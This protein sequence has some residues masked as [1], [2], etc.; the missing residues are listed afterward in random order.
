MDILS[1]FYETCLGKVN[2]AKRQ[3]SDLTE[4][5]QQLILLA[6]QGHN[7][8]VDACI[9]SG[10]TS[11]IQVLCDEFRDKKILYLTYNTL[12]KLDAQ[13]KISNPNAKVT[14]YHGYV[15][16]VLLSH[17]ITTGVSDMLQRFNR[18]KPPLP[19]SF[20]M[21]VLDE[22]QDIEQEIA[23]M[24][25]YVK[26]QNPGVQIIAVGDMAQKIYDKTTLNVPAFID[27]FLGT[28]DKLCFTK[29]FRLNHDHAAMLGRIWN[30][31]INGVNENCK[32]RVMDQ[33]E[34]VAYLA[35]Q[36]PEDVLCLGSRT[37]TLTEVL[38]QLEEEVPN[39][40]N[41]NTTYASIRD[42]DGN[43]RPSEKNAIFTTY[44]SAKGLERKICVV[45]DFTESYWQVRSSIAMTKY[46]IL[47]NIFCVAASR[48]KDEII[49]VKDR[50]G[51][52][53][54]SEETL[55]CPFIVNDE[56]D[57][58]FPISSMFDF[59]Y[60]E[61]VEEAYSYLT[62]KE[63]SRKDHAEIYV[64]SL[65]GLIDLSPCIGIYQEA[66]F[67]RNYDIDA[68]I[69]FQKVMSE[70]RSFPKLPDGASLDEKILYLTMMETTQNRYFEQVSPPFVDELRASAIRKRLQ[71]VFDGNEDVQMH[72]H[73]AFLDQ[74]DVPCVARGMIDVL[75]DGMIYELKFVQEL[76]HEHFLQLACYLVAMNMRKGVLWNT[77]TNTMYG[78]TVL[79]KNRQA[80]MDAVVNAVT[81]GSVQTYRPAKV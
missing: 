9:G 18:V 2:P 39:V 51:A 53:L 58:P 40:Y 72:C 33:D 26:S 74:D 8:L 4:E 35:R 45:F 41:K 57:K 73:L 6:K 43:S 11:T 46:E 13:N 32:I 63:I 52:G 56:F 64:K 59:K 80:F 36:K 47:R 48:G 10:K 49:F 69:M 60:K 68:A 77:R 27:R 29:C 37:G 54:L 15:Y 65:D 66:S 14:N 1:M 50:K 16:G 79:K 34:V 71:T 38:N 81:K 22:Y 42:R 55:S 44:D 17:G 62:I 19:Y 75:K 30:K 25:D 76:Q 67:F 7:V 21:I 3:F 12:L 5:Q 70:E 23:E 24:L 78:V 31:Q 61:S 28:Y 20:D